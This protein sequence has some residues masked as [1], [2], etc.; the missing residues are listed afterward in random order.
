MAATAIKRADYGAARDALVSA[1]RVRRS[2]AVAE[3][4]G[5]L[6]PHAPD[7][8]TAHLASIVAARV[9]ASLANFEKLAKTDDPRLASWVLAALADPPFCSP[10]SGPFLEALAET[11][12]RLRDPRL[13]ARLP[14][15]RAILTARVTRKP[16]YTRVIAILDRGVATRPPLAA[17][18]AA[19]VALETALVTEL[20]PLR[21]SGVSRESLLAEVYARPL[22]DAPRMVFADFLLE[23]GDPYGEFITLQLAR[24]RHGDPSPREQ[25]LLKRHGKEWLG[26]LATVLR[27]NK[28]YSGTRFARGF[29]SVA[30]FIF[31]IEKKIQLVLRDEMWSTVE[32]LENCYE[33]RTLLTHAPLRALRSIVIDPILATAL[34]ERTEPFPGVTRIEIT[35]NLT[36]VPVALLQRLFPARTTLELAHLPDLTTL[37]RFGIVAL[38]IDQH[39]AGALLAER[40]GAHLAFIASLASAPPLVE[41]ISI[42]AP[43]C[44]FPGPPATSY[45][46]GDRGYV[47]A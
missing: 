36:T 14:E 18:P 10:T 16:I 29:L 30:D 5:L 20:A 31:K 19:E 9:T 45:V 17:A 41:R 37:D 27:L 8:M 34:A 24:G 3:L 40:T 28:S 35:A 1:W 15:I 7:A 13:D 21:S 33:V 2:P 46:R 43:W 38:E 42:R 44:A 22:D 32:E 25:E 26:N 47:I 4:V 23:H 11:I 39:C 12:V 6:D